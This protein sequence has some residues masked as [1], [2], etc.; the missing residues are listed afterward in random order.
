M[1]KILAVL[2]V[3]AIAFG[4][5][6]EFVSVTDA[7][8]NGYGDFSGLVIDFDATT[9]LAADWTPDLVDGQV[10]SVDSISVWAR[11]ATYD[12]DLYLGVYSGVAKTNTSG[13]YT[14]G[15]FLGASDATVNLATVGT[16]KVTWDFSGINVTADNVAGGG[17]GEL[18]FVLQTATTAQNQLID[19]GNTA[20][21]R[22][23][24]GGDGSYTDE[25]AAILHDDTEFLKTARTPEYEAQ[26]TAI[27]EPATLSMIALFGVGVLFI[28]R[29]LM[30]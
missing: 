10:Y 18:F 24:D 25:L 1:K 7:D 30:I 4:V 20:G 2:T 28:R 29:R 23:I 14:Y 5:Q 15:S 6:A 13:A 3:S 26:I 12:A 22:R 17:S 11:S 21:I 8:S 19:V 9:G 16:G 27:P